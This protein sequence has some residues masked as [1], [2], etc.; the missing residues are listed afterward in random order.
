MIKKIFYISSKLTIIFIAI[1]IFCLLGYLN[2]IYPLWQ[3]DCIYLY[4]WG[5]DQ[6]V[7]NIGDIFVSQY[8]HYITWGGR[9]I[10]H[11]IA[12]LLLFIGK[13]AASFI[14][15]MAF[16]LLIYLMY[17]IANI[18]QK[19]NWILF[20]L[21]FL[22]TYT[23]QAHIPN[24]FYWITGSANYL[25]GT[26]LILIFI[27][28]YIRF[29]LQKY[30]ANNSRTS[31]KHIFQSCLFLFL[32]I[33]AGW[34]NENMG[35]SLVAFLTLLIGYLKYTS[36][37]PPLWMYFGLAG[38]II[39]ATF[40]V[41][42]PG[43]FVRL[44]ASVETPTVWSRVGFALYEI[45]KRHMVIT[46]LTI[47]LI[48]F[49]YRKKTCN[50]NILVISVL[51][52][53]FAFL[54]IAAMSFSP[55]FPRRAWFGIITLMLIASGMLLVN[56]NLKNYIQ[57]KRILFLV[58]LFGIIFLSID[59]AKRIPYMKSINSF[60]NEREQIVNE[61]K[62]RG[63]K[64]IVFDKTYLM[65]FGKYDTADITSDSTHWRNK[66]YQRFW[67]LNSVRVSEHAKMV[68]MKHYYKEKT[69]N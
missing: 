39:G 47:G 23:L 48:I 59:Y 45:F 16:V 60:W 61:A 40:L 20:L 66:M 36:K 3:D 30:T 9:S 44:D 38:A 2:Y 22:G 42:A 18:G 69:Q 14:N 51:L 1:I 37:K 63:E 68:N 29:F 53:I 41:L 8:Y 31:T 24:T 6:L 7:E 52:T 15:T 13:P 19:S 25:W 32:G 67:G 17:R 64:D 35:V 26:L 5:T 10:V 65:S 49:S 62:S 4:I 11:F 50:K 12:Q 55:E 57:Y 58:S 21:M 43:N 27:H 46:I 54:A 34:T 56:S 33:L 28:P